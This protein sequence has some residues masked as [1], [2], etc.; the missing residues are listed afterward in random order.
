M[1]PPDTP[2]R[3]QHQRYAPRTAPCPRCGTPGRRKQYLTRLVRGL[4][5]KAILL[6]RV[7]TAEYR[8]AC[9]CCQTFRTQVPGVTPRAQYT[10]AVREAVLD[11]LLDDHLSAEATLAALRR[12]FLLELSTGFLYDCLAWKARQVNHAAYRAFAR[13]CFSGTLCVDELHLGRY[14]LLVATDPLRDLPVAFALVSKNDQAHMGRFLGQLR[15]HGFHPRVVITDGSPLYPSLSARLWPRARHQLCAF[16]VLRDLLDYVLAAVR[17]RIRA[18]RRRAA[19]PRRPRR[20]GRPPQAAA[21]ARR[22]R[23]SLAEQAA[24]VWKHR[25]LI[26][27]RR[28]R[29]SAARQALLAK[30]LAYQPSLQNLRRFADDLYRLFDPAQ[31]AAQAWHRWAEVLAEPDYVEDPALAGA[32]GLLA[33]GTFGKVIAYLR[34]PAG[35]RERTNNHAERTNRGLRRAER[36]RYRWRSARSIVRFVLLQWHRRWERRWAAEAGGGGPRPSPGGGRGGT[37]PP[38]ATRGD[39]GL[40]EAGRWAA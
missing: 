18:F 24:F 38:R 32:R 21:R 19:R 35:S 3:Y 40:R 29:L 20:R 23:Q 39:K 27:A 26:V 11:R 5:Y 1:I 12:D 37:A 30:V 36:A 6:V 25:F 15:D 33:A 34:G 7:T 4:A 14:T 10:D 8:A 13:A 16:H 17:Q 22:G 9:A 2:I 28:E 31:S